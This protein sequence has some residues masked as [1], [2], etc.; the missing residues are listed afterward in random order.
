[1]ADVIKESKVE[2]TG[3]RRGFDFL[4][5]R[6]VA[7]GISVILSIIGLV[8]IVAIATGK[9][10]LGTDFSGGM[11]IQYR[12]ENPVVIE[13]VR[14]AFDRGGVSDADI[15]EFSGAQKLLVKVRKT[16]AGLN[17]LAASV[18]SALTAAMPGN[19]FIIEATTEIGPTV[20]KKLQRD[21]FWA[22]IVSLFGILF[23]IAWRFEFRF[24]VAAVLATFHDVLALVGIIFIF[25]M[26]MNLLIVTALLT[27]AGYSINDTV[28]VFDRI[29]ENLRKQ[30]KSKETLIDLINRS[31]NETLS[32]T[33]VTGGS[34]LLVLLVPLI[35]GGEVIYDFLLALL[36][37]I[38]I[39]TYSSIFV[40]SPLLL[41]WK[42]KGKLIK[43]EEKG[44]D[45]KGGLLGGLGRD[46]T[47]SRPIDVSRE[48]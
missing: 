37:G 47:I 34:T 17:E 12:F 42:G 5:Y 2:A 15:Q 26:E 11:A 10:N 27:I 8:A 19:P 9:A 7:L 4:G 40:A 29:R 48:V 23:Y 36:I 3:A 39:G 44:D 20:G 41:I 38:L 14:A 35:L 46:T 24:G 28:V 45:G 21:A 31:V 16:D 13:Q 6:K 22:I 25:N 43:D 1:M 32:R 18:G 33:M 30:G